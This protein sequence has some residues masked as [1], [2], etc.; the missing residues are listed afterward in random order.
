MIISQSAKKAI[1]FDY[2]RNAFGGTEYMASNFIK[3]ILPEM[4]KLHNY[5]SVVVPGNVPSL[6]SILAS[7]KQ[8]IMWM[9]NTPQQFGDD[10]LKFL[11]NEKFINVIKYIVVPSKA[12]KKL[13][14]EAMNIDPDKVYVVNNAIEPLIYNPNKFKDIKQVKLIHTSSPDRGLDVLLNA[15]NMIEEDFRLEIYNSFN[16]DAYPDLPNDNRV[17]FYGFTPKATVREAYEQSHIHAY[18]STYPETF[19]ISQVEAMSAGLLC[20]TSDY[21]ALPEVSG[22]LTTMYPYVEDRIEHAKIFAEQLTTAIKQ[23]KS[24]NWNPEIEI[25]YAN[26]TY[27]WEAIKK[28]WLVFHELI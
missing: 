25:E 18:P 2:N 15:V 27:S 20:V 26:N 21:G 28:D 23:I 11:Q 6:E 10:K 9:H 8:V 14:L 13:L 7:K 22:G 19:C 3:R 17:R 1:P 16:P 5:I 24:G 12:H 4:P